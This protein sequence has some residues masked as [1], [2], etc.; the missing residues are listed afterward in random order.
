MDEAWLKGIY[1]TSDVDI[2]KDPL[3]RV[4]GQEDAISLARIAAAQKRN[5]LL[6]GPPGTGKSMIALA[7]SFHLPQPTEEV[8]VVDNPENP[9]RPFIEVRSADEVRREWEDRQSAEGELINPI[10]APVKVAEELNY[11]CVRCGIYSPPSERICPSCGEAKQE[12]QE[13]ATV[14]NPFGDL[15]GVV[16]MT[17]TQMGVEMPS[18]KRRVKTTRKVGE[19]EEVVVYEPAGEAAIKIL[20]EEALEKRHDIERRSPRKVLVPLNRKPFVLAAGASETELLGD[21]VDH[22]ALAGQTLVR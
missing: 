2:P 10:D 14:S 6:V 13:K 20:D 16:E 7:L 19:R 4:V 8:Q 17:I 22:V 3:Q 5:L 1:R 18:R 11:R 15:L 9:E 12:K 21:G